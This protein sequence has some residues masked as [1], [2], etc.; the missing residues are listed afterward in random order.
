[1]KSLGGLDRCAWYAAGAMRWMTYNILKGGQT[2]LPELLEIIAE[3]RPDVL[4]LQECNDFD[5]DG[6]ARLREVQR[7]LGMQGVLGRSSSGYH[8]AL[9]LRDATWELTHRSGAR[10]ARAWAG[11]VVQVAGLRLQAISVHLNPHEP[12]ARLREVEQLTALLS[13]ELPTLIMGDFNAVSARDVPRMQPGQWAPRFRARH[14]TADGQRLD[15]RA[16]RRLEEA[17]LVD[18]AAAHQPQPALTRP[19]ALYAHRNMPAQRLDYIFATPDLAGRVQRVAVLDD[20][21]TQRASDHL[22]VVADVAPAAA[23]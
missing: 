18:L 20:P 7:A 8:V 9:L 1:M 11:A 3:Q 21:R 12:P 4:A 14:L 17:G 19:T 6:E 2:R 10:F 16:L 5:R 15:T 13:P 22:P 23:D